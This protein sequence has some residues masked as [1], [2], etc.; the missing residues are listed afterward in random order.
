MYIEARS[1]RCII[2]H[3]Y[4][5]N[6]DASPYIVESKV[7]PE[8]PMNTAETIATATAPMGRIPTNGPSQFSGSVNEV[9]LARRV[10]LAR[11]LQLAE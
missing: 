5:L 9:W 2:P 8:T 1:K 4:R 7:I 6:I 11:V 3:G 10:T